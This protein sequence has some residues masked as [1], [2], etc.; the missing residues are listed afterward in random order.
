MKVAF[1]SGTSIL[2]SRLFESWEVRETATA[3]GPVTYRARG[4]FLILNRHGRSGLTPP[5]AVNHRANIQALADLGFSAV[6]S[7]NSVGSLQENLQPGSFISCSDYVCLH[8][9]TFNDEIGNYEAPFVTNN[10]IPAIVAK[11]DFPVATGKVYVQMV[12]PRFETPAEVR[13][14]RHWG[15]VVGMNMAS[16]AD[17]C[18][19][20]GLRY[21]SLCMI[22]NYANG[23]CN[24]PISG[25]RFRR[26][27]AENQ[28]KVNRLFE[29]LFQLFAG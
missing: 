25:E 2:K 12:G 4:E 26:L 10:L 22:D 5:H 3:F 11:T 15:D 23:I 8:P 19:E 6:I 29:Q 13:I 24:E 27:V 18:R 1:L 7:L 16:E 20:A 28:A 17:L 21:N 14:I 9:S